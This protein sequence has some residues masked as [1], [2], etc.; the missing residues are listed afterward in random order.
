MARKPRVEFRGATYRIFRNLFFPKR[1]RTESVAAKAE[2]TFRNLTLSTFRLPGAQDT[3]PNETGRPGAAA[4]ALREW[5]IS[6]MSSQ[7]LRLLTH[8]PT[9]L[10]S[11]HDG[12]RDSRP[13]AAA[14]EALRNRPT[15]GCRIFASVEARISRRQTRG[16][17]DDA[18]D[19]RGKEGPLE[20]FGDAA[21]TC[22]GRSPSIRFFQTRLRRF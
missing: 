17:A 4:N 19:E 8:Q 14:F 5:L 3:L 2:I 6:N 21:R 18:R 12:D 7:K 22:L 10:V 9:S 1:T 15:H 16:H 11:A 20:G 13:Q